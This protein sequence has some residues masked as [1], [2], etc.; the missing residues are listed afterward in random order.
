M[1][2]TVPKRP[3][4][5][6]REIHIQEQVFA[7]IREMAAMVVAYYKALRDEGLTAEEALALTTARQSDMM[8]A[9]EEEGE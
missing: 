2:P 6:P 7:A 8:L 4:S 9:G 1:V 3:M 5:D